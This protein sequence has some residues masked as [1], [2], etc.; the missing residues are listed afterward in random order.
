[1]KKKIIFSLILAAT[2]GLIT[3][4]FY[5]NYKETIYALSLENIE[6][7]A[8]IENTE[9]LATCYTY[10]V[11]SLTTEVY[12]CQGQL[13]DKPRSCSLVA[14]SLGKQGYEK[15]CIEK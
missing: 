15:K 2:T 11:F 6:A 4:T 8:E 5:S 14:W 9:K 13:D 7:L 1:M 12:G 10:Y 3:S